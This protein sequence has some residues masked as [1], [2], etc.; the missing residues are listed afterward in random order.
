MR[1]LDRSNWWQILTADIL[2]AVLAFLVAFAFTFGAS[3]S[4]GQALT[5]F[6]VGLLGVGLL[7]VSFY[8]FGL[9]TVE[10]LRDKIRLLFSATKAC[11]TS[12]LLLVAF[13]FAMKD[14]SFPRITML[15]LFI[16]NLGLI[17]A[18]RSYIDARLLLKSEREAS[19]I[20]IVGAGNAGARI[21]TQM[22]SSLKKRYEIVG[23]IDDD[24]AKVGS[25]VSGFEVLGTREDMKRVIRDHRVDRV[26]IAMPSAHRSTISEFILICNESSTQ[27]SIVPSFFEIIT[28]KAPM[29]DTADLLLMSFFEDPIRRE[30]KIV[31]RGFDVVVS[32]LGLILLSPLFLLVAIAIKLTSRG[33][34]FYSQL[35]VGRGGRLFKIYKFRTMVEDADKIGPPLTEKNDARI[36]AVGRFLRYSSIDELPQLLNVLKGEMSL[37]GPRP[38]IPSIVANYQKWQRRVLDVKPGMTGLAQVSGRDDLSINEKLRYDLYYMR[39]HCL[40]LDIKIIL[41]TIHKVLQQEGV[42]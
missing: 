27:Y 13:V 16:L 22:R 34:V 7:L 6:R 23:F 1:L 3:E 41:K 2:L 25:V 28:R 33:P 36:T 8:Y 40:S 14:I 12:T 30:Q 29:D 11:A 9:Y 4:L 24:R 42:N 19:R 38:E 32:L 18:W 5:H 17:F 21:A 20:L 31:K 15:Y 37:V 10:A 39:N 26:V 35:R